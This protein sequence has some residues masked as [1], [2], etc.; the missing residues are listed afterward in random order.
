MTATPGQA[1]VP[2]VTQQRDFW[3]LVGYAVVLGVFGAFAA[4]I[5]VGAITFGGKW[6]SDSQPGWFGGH[7]WWVAEDAQVNTRPASQ[8]PTAGCSRAP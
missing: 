6:Y 7:W 2:P 1:A 8:A 3:V 5:F 4:L